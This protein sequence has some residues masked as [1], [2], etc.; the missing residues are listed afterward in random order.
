MHSKMEE[1][2]GRGKDK[3]HGENDNGACMEEGQRE[4]HCIRDVKK[5]LGRI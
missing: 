1:K 3:K 4:N 5:Q 2:V